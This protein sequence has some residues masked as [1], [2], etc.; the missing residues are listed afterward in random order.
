MERRLPNEIKSIDVWYRRTP[1]RIT[2][3]DGAGPRRIDRPMQGRFLHHRS[4]QVRRM[5]RTQ[6][7]PDLVCRNLGH[8]GQDGTRL[9]DGTGAQTSRA[10]RTSTRHGPCTEASA[11]NDSKAVLSR[12]P[13]RRN[14][15]CWR[16]PGNGLGQHLFEGLPLPRH[17]VLRHHE[18]RQVHGREGRHRSRQPRRPRQRL[19]QVGTQPV[20]K[21]REANFASL[22]FCPERPAFTRPLG[23]SASRPPLTAV[24]YASKC[25]GRCGEASSHRLR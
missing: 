2:V 21:K 6:G 10:C 1:L 19:H 18:G 12:V 5:P 22:F 13:P 23:R 8:D 9:E 25:S 7:H 4:Q 14:S 20:H 11:C 24:W 15:R 17:Q 16:R 3:D